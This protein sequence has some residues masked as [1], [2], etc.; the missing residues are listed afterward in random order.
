MSVVV[1][2][3]RTLKN[4]SFHWHCLQLVFQIDNNASSASN[5]SKYPHFVLGNDAD[6]LLLLLSLVESAL[7]L[8]NSE[9]PTVLSQDVLLVISIISAGSKDTNELV[10]LTQICCLVFRLTALCPSSPRA[11]LP[12]QFHLLQ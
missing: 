12:L 10:L 5:L 4:S 2:D 8:F 7:F 6:T 1:T 9:C 11:R 3:L